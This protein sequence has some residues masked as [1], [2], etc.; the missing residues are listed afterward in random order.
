MLKVNPGQLMHLF[1][2]V[3]GDSEVL[4][5]GNG[6]ILRDVAVCGNPKG[7]VEHFIAG[8]GDWFENN[9]E[10]LCETVRFVVG[11]RGG[12]VSLMRER[13]DDG[14]DGITRREED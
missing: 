10:T 11:D 14:Y 6:H 9:G 4:G 13:I 1:G 12:D 5:C 2:N 8:L 7:V 3:T